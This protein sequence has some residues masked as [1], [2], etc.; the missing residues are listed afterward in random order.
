[1]SFVPIGFDNPYQYPR[2]YT[3]SSSY[4]NTKASPEDQEQPGEV[5][6]LVNTRPT[7]SSPRQNRSTQGR[8]RLV[9]AD[10]VAFRYLEEDPATDAIERWGRLQGYEL[11][12]VEQW[13]CSRTHPT[14]VIST[15]T[16][17]PSHSIVV[18]VLSVPSDESTWSQRLQVYFNAVSQFHAKEKETPLGTLMVTN[19]S[20][21]PSALTVIAVPDG[22]VRKHREDFI[23]NENL[24]RMGCS[25]R[26]PLSLQPPQSSTIAKFHHLYRTSE[27]VP[28]YHSVMELVRICQTALV[29]Y[30]K[31]Q[32]TYADG[33]LCDV[34]E[35]AVNNW[36]TDIGTYFYNVE[37]SDGILGP[38]TVAALLGLLI[39]AYN[40]LKASGSPVG[41]DVLDTVSMKRA[42]G[43]FQK[44]Q[45]MERTRRLDRETLDRLH[46]ATAKNASGEGWTV[47]KAV[48]STVA[49]LSG[50]GGEMMMGIVGGR[51]K[52][53][54]SDA[55]TLDIDRF[56]QLVTGPRMKWLWQ[57]K[58][59]KSGDAL[60]TPSD[61][62][63]GRIFSTDDQGNFFWTSNQHDSYSDGGIL[64]RSDTVYS[65]QTHDLKAVRSRPRGPGA[66]NKAH[67]MRHP[68]DGE[69]TRDWTESA[70]TLTSKSSKDHHHHMRDHTLR[71]SGPPRQ[72]GPPAFD[73]ALANAA[74]TS[75]KETR[76]QPLR[77]VET[78]TG[79]R[80]P[81]HREQLRPPQP[82][83]SPRRKKLNAE[84]AGLRSVFETDIYRN[85]SAGKPYMGLRSRALRSSQ[86]AI[87]LTDHTPDSPR[88]NRIKRQLSFSIVENAVLDLGPNVAEEGI[89]KGKIEGD[90]TNALAERD[91]LVAA[92]QKKAKRIQ[93][94]QQALI[95]YTESTVGHVESLERYSRQHLEELNELY[96]HRLEEYQSLQATSSDLV[97]QEKNAL[98]ES[99]RRIEMLGAKMDYELDSL[100]SRLQEVEDGVDDFE[101]NVIAIEARVR[102][103]IGDEKQNAVPWLQRLL[104][105]MGSRG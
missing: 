71:P 4:R 82:G 36:W 68:I 81:S 22:D 6:S 33:L 76:R 53:G 63:G 35:R 103:L 30:D 55:E 47:P 93:T 61:D 3:R 59:V 66:G 102:E 90:L 34:T 12:L 77:R 75:P 24:K 41:K 28:L 21:F 67:S 19:L 74:P 84:L 83:D 23:V 100:Q 39:G 88:Q 38:T 37:P 51:D 44:S 72:M 40:R 85:F 16:G 13:A 9:F 43:H 78:D 7:T 104:T 17:D 25:G 50:K 15:Y 92:A 69:E 20:G 45:K 32:A 87:Q 105:F 27:T 95:P 94:I 8:K 58:R 56:A 2:T 97:S 62:L 11:Y 91:A 89:G 64:E 70:T 14:F 49:E 5:E 98:S 54:I 26:A 96:Y 80:I 10:P 31:I 65:T 79:K 73:L 18:N 86:S 48:K 101:R 42:V 99:F 52:A 60:T 29:M 1:M 57:G 46:R